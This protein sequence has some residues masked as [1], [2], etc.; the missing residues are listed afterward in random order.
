MWGTDTVTP[1]DPVQGG[2][3]DCWLVASASSIAE[4]PQRLKDI[5]KV[6]E[7]NKVGVYALQMYLLG[8]PIT[9][10]IDDYL[11]F[12]IDH[13]LMLL[14]SMIS[15][16]K[17]V[18]FP[19]FE[20]AA[21]KYLG[22]YEM[23]YGGYAYAAL[24]MFLGVP[25]DY[26]YTSSYT[27]DELWEIFTDEDSKNSM[28][29]AG[30]YSGGG[31]DQDENENGVPYSHAYTVLST[32]T[33]EDG[34]RLVRMRNPWNKEKFFGD[35]S[36]RSETWTEA[37]RAEAGDMFGND[38]E[39]FMAIE[40]FSTNYS[41]ITIAYDIQGWHRSYEGVFADDEPHD[42]TQ[43]CLYDSTK[44]NQYKFNLSSSVD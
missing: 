44:Y 13:P 2:I 4:D 36:D 20:K 28:I 5:F 37:L 32:L 34:T 1:N 27:A 39:Y 19:L 6:Q 30:S 24:E 43:L 29:T 16:D 9:V 10:T 11:P 40:D 41:S 33:L 21:A 22:N 12:D 7:T 18:W 17:A 23:I 8:T 38:G 14:Y 26:Y 25:N 3:G 15:L 35:W 31:S 42:P